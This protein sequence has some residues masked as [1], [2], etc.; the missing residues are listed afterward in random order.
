MGTVVDD[1]WVSQPIVHCDT[2]FPS[3]HNHLQTPELCLNI[4]DY[5]LKSYRFKNFKISKCT[6]KIFIIPRLSKMIFQSSIFKIIFGTI[7]WSKFGRVFRWSRLIF[8]LNKN[9]NYVIKAD[10][11]SFTFSCLNNHFI[12]QKVFWR[13]YLESANCR[14]I[15]RELLYQYMEFASAMALYSL[16]CLISASICYLSWRN[17]VQLP[18][19][20]TKL[21]T[22][23]TCWTFFDKMWNRQKKTV[24]LEEQHS[25]KLS[26]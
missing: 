23:F 10:E 15:S 6:C 16:V 13:K 2:S 14:Y 8:Y 25:L 12:T 11:C 5:L 26:K 18:K 4:E 21:E 22:Y 24:K 9:E 20:R 7:E 3:H 1:M 19:C 17:V